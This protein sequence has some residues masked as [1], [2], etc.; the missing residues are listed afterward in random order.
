[1]NTAGT[2]CNREGWRE[3]ADPRDGAII[4]GKPDRTSIRIGPHYT[5]R[6]AVGRGSR[7]L[8]EDLRYWIELTDFA[9]RKFCEP[10][11]TYLVKCEIIRC[12][13]WRWDK[14]LLPARIAVVRHKL[15]DGIYR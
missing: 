13:V 2:Q 4:F 14:V 5:I 10:E 11:I 6:I 1:M 15:A 7:G 3:P 8:C 12:R 9:C